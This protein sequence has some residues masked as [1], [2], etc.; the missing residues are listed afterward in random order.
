LSVLEMKDIQH[1]VDEVGHSRNR[2]ERK[3]IRKKKEV[4]S[5]DL[6]TVDVRREKHDEIKPETGKRRWIT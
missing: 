4:R 5:R 6:E 3:C 2:V 1:I